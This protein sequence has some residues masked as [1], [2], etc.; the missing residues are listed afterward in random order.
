[1]D[2]IRSFSLDLYLLAI[3]MMIHGLQEQAHPFVTAMTD[4]LLES[5]NRANRPQIV[6][7]LMRGANAKYQA[8][9]ETMAQLVDECEYEHLL[10]V[11]SSATRMRSD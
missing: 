5:N 6:K 7:S 10:I 8:D 3:L 11:T 2:S 1:M 4:F 9:M